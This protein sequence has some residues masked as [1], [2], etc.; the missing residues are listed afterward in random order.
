[1]FG[2]TKHVLAHV[3]NL[4]DHGFN[5]NLSWEIHK[6]TS[7]YQCSSKRCNLCLSEKV[8]TICADPNN[9]LNKRAEL[10]SKCRNRNKFL[11]ATLKTQNKMDLFCVAIF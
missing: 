1:M 2:K 6:R 7:P 9:L 4:N 3:W 8:S 11:L 5:S 10:I